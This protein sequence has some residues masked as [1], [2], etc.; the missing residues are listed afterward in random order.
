MIAGSLASVLAVAW[1]IW[2]P[3]PRELSYSLLATWGEQGS[4]PG[5]FNEPTGVAVHDGEV[6]VSDA[7]N[8]RIQIF[9]T[10]GHFK[11]Q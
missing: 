5:Q 1:F 11:R 4:G 8:A 6:F 10:E 9:D 3:S 7:R 2:V